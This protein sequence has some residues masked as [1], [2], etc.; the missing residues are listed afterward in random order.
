MS[1]KIKTVGNKTA[2]S[3]PVFK[4]PPAAS[5]IP[6]TIVGPAAAPKSPAS[7]KNANIAVP[8]RGHFCEERLIVPGHI[9]PTAS[10]QR[11]HPIRPSTEDADKDA[12]R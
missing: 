2:K 6:P 4:S 10:P 12:V 9:M 11:A 5:A 8:P 7:A 3:N 1:P